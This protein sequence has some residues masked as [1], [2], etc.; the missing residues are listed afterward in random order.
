LGGVG[1]MLRR[2]KAGAGLG[3]VAIQA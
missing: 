1:L 2:A 3:S